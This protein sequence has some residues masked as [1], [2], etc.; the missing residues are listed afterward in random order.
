MR[1]LLLSAVLLSLPAFASAGAIERACLSSEQANGNRTL[2]SCIQQAADRTLS[3]K[4][5]RFAA[6]LF[7]DPD[8]AQKVRMSDRRSDEL[9]WERYESFGAFAQVVCAQS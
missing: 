6:R 2:C 3:A 9:F 7:R 8:R 4:D 1:S 5:Q